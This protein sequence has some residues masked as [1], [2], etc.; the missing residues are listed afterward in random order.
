MKTAISIP[1]ELF[2]AAEQYAR[3]HGVTRS[4][5]YSQAVA[6]FLE[7]HSRDQITQKLNDVYPDQPNEI[8][9]T[10]SALQF[11]SLEQEEW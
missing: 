4:N 1:N 11:S 6:Q 8:N 7:N 3:S 10:I 2:Q 5:L 9:R